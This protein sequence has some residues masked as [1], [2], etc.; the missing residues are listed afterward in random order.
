MRKKS[1]W[2][3]VMGLFLTVAFLGSFSQTGEDLFQKALRLERNEGKLMEAIQLYNK[4][5]AEGGN[6]SLAAQA[7]LRIGLC[8]EKLGQRNI[9]NAQEA[10]QKVLDNFPG[11]TEAVKLAKQKLSLIVQAKSVMPKRDLGVALYKIKSNP[12]IDEYAAVSPDGR[13]I[14]FVDWKTGDLAVFDIQSGKK[15]LLTDKGPWTKSA[16]FALSS[17]W[18]PDGKKLV[19]DWYGREYYDLRVLSLDSVE[20]KT[21]LRIPWD[22]PGENGKAQCWDWSSDGAR[23]LALIWKNDGSKQIVSISVADGNV[24]IIKEL[25]RNNPTDIYNL[26]FSPE[27]NYIAYDFPSDDNSSEHDIFLLAS[28]GEKEMKLVDYPGDDIFLGFLPEGKHFLFSSDRGGAWDIWMAA[29]GDG[30]D[31]KEPELIKSNIGNIAPLGITQKGAFCYV[32]LRS[33][34][35]VFS[36]EI[37]PENGKLLTP[38]KKLIK[39][40]EGMNNWPDYSADGK[41]IA[42]LSRRNIR[43]AQRTPLAEGSFICIYSLDDGEKRDIST[44]LNG[45][46]PPVWSPGGDSLLIKGALDDDSLGLYT[47]DVKTGEAEPVVVDKAIGD[48][49]E[50]SVDGKSIFY[51]RN[52]KKEKFSEILKRDLK[53]GQEIELYR[54]DEEKRISISLSPDGMWLAILN[55]YPLRERH[56]KIMP[57]AGGKPK[58]LHAFQ[59]RTG[60]SLSP[61][62]SAD[63][64]SV[65]FPNNRLSENEE[66][67]GSFM[68]PW[69]LFCI[70]VDGGEPREIGFGVHLLFRPRIHPDGKH[71][72]FGSFGKIEDF[73]KNAM[74]DTGIWLMENFLPKK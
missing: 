29:V 36:A 22:S 71:V 50:W 30:D 33:F 62:W 11:Q 40:Q 66:M 59:Q 14:S 5:V 18:S 37:D 28:D 64:K 65:I 51:V 32:H 16:E 69:S 3:G 15:R 31:P 46:S 52:S 1:F 2:F 60:H 68:P 61:T 49:Y 8:F 27:G 70:P 47:V 55:N 39:Y 48:S 21:L 26:R 13:Y 19:Y 4:V 56:L 74:R 63:G 54:V 43:A 72:V 24:Q 23:I 9:K 38:P 44:G 58:D 35:N 53:S 12:M 20:P 10:F 45:F 57:V 34:F 17:R 6:E 25:T 42:Y 7:Q 41:S 73:K 67:N